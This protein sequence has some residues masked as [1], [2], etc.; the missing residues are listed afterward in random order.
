MTRLM[1][2]GPDIWHATHVFKIGWMPVSTRMTVVRLDGQR[3][4]LHSP[5]PLDADLR[6]ELAALGEVSA[7]VAPNKAHHLFFAPCAAAYPEAKLYA[8]PGLAR[9]RPDLPPAHTLTPIPPPYW[10]AALD[11]VFIEDMP[12]VNETVWFHRP[13]GTLIVTD[14]VQCW[15]GEL[16]WSARGYARATG[17]RN[18]LAVPHTVRA[19]V[20][21]RA[22]FLRSCE[23]LL[24]WP[25][26]RIVMAHNAVIEDDA[27]ARLRKALMSIG[28]G[29]LD[30][31]N[32]AE[33]E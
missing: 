30:G 20:R 3:L 5:I 10:A 25:I 1:P 4:W 21:D 2:L 17:V 8:A 19:L 6:S 9:K 11:Q 13:S 29:L 14:I 26:K 12:W 28:I 18:K 33:G 22:A 7:V 31:P 15:L 23:R 24:T 32:P 16:D 27:A